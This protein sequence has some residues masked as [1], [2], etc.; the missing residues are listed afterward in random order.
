LRPRPILTESWI[1][2]GLF[3]GNRVYF[4]QAACQIWARMFSAKN[5]LVRVEILTKFVSCAHKSD[6]KAGG[7]EQEQGSPH[8]AFPPKDGSVQSS[9][10]EADRPQAET[11]SSSRAA[12]CLPAKKRG[13][14]SGHE[15]RGKGKEQGRTVRRART[16]FSYRLLCGPI[17][18]IVTRMAMRPSANVF[19]R[20]SSQ[21][22]G[23]PRIC[24][25]QSRTISMACGCGMTS[26]LPSIWM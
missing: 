6:R 5:Q 2:V 25:C 14:S 18:S 11:R 8:K 24:R 9:V 13:K 12:P 15:R 21:L 16:R 22:S 17:F 19:S 3:H 7:R 23:S 10:A 20:I 4:E 26:A 1:I